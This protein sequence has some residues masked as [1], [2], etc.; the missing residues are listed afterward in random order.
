V[1]RGDEVAGSRRM[2]DAACGDGSGRNPVIGEFDRDGT[3]SMSLSEEM[4]LDVT[5][6]N[7]PVLL[8]LM[9]LT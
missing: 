2:V 6:V 5:I 8:V 7:W 4:L 1:T 3:L 9:R